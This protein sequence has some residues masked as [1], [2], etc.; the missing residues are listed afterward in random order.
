MSPEIWSNNEY[1][2]SSDVY[3]FA[4]IAYEIMT[5]EELFKDY[6]IFMLYSKVIIN[7]ERPKFKFPIPNCY[8]NLITRCWSPNPERR[9]TFQEIVEE[10]NNNDEFIFDMIDKEEYYNYIDYIKNTG[11][12]FNPTKRLV[13]LFQMKMKKN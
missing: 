3:A 7:G 1:T 6:N 2:K 5:L 8:Q 9:P 13:L 10:L 4:I 11:N 12:T